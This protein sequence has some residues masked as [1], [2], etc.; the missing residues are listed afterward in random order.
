M[1]TVFTNLLL[2]QQPKRFGEPNMDIE[3][4]IRI[5]SVLSE[6][7]HQDLVYGERDCNLMVLKIFE[8]ERYDRFVG[9]YK[10]IIGGAR[11]AKKEFGYVRIDD[12]MADS[13]DYTEID[14]NF[15][16]FGDIIFADQSRVAMIAL[17]VNRAFVIDPKTDK[18]AEGVV[19]I[20]PSYKIFRRV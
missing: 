8:P 19:Q 15:M 11:V 7:V 4:K 18:F 13:D 10:S 12:Y 5:S 16:M 2:V 1:V 14:P 3:S 9:R 17:G 20:P 6:Y